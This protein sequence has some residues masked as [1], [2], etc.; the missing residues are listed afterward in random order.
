VYPEATGVQTSFL[1]ADLGSVEWPI[2]QS[3]LPKMAVLMGEFGTYEG[4]FPDVVLAGACFHVVVL[5]PGNLCNLLK[6]YR[7]SREEYGSASEFSI[8]CNSF[9]RTFP[10]DC[11]S[12][13]LF[14]GSKLQ[15][16]LQRMAVLDLGL[17]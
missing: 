8:G 14:S 12:F 6:I 13:N 3:N 15:L 5:M 7:F 9:Y 16:R 4:T 11:S 10:V 17:Q 2:I 1:A